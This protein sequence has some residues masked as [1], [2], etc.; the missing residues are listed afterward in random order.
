M[1]VLPASIAATANAVKSGARNP[2]TALRH[3]LRMLMYYMYTPLLRKHR[4]LSANP[5]LALNGVE[6]KKAA[7][8]AFLF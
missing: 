6:N 7:S 5:S 3:F 2:H 1:G 8:A 4:A